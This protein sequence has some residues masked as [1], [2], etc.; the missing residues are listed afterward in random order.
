MREASLSDIYANTATTTTDDDTDTFL[1]DSDPTTIND[2]DR[3]LSHYREVLKGL[4]R[5]TVADILETG[6][7]FSEAQDRLLPAHYKAL[8]VEFG[9]EKTMVSRLRTIYQCFSVVANSQLSKLPASVST[10]Y[11]MSRLEHQV[12]EAGLRDAT[13]TTET[14]AKQVQALLP[15]TEPKK[16]PSRLNQMRKFMRKYREEMEIE[17]ADNP[18]LERTIPREILEIIEAAKE[19]RQQGN[20]HAQDDNATQ[21]QPPF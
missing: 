5:K 9:F 2:P 1:I 8:M 10:L 21:P 13:F 16:P 17:F 14:T 12:L 7:V 4:W 3:L 15:P 6:R 18:V 19:R 20:G 11:H